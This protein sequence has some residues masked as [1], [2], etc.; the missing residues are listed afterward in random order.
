MSST[1]G[2][3]CHEVRAVEGTVLGVQHPRLTVCPDDRAS[4]I[5]GGA[6]G[7]SYHV[8]PPGHQ[9]LPNRGLCDPTVDGGGGGTCEK[10]P[11]KISS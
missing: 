2:S 7:A 1:F 10:P 4:G 8:L 5:G 11:R 9:Q 6:P 3:I